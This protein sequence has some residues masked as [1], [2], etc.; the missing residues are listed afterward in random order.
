MIIEK[1]KWYTAKQLVV[2]A[3]YVTEKYGV[4]F[5][6]SKLQDVGTNGRCGGAYGCNVLAKIN[7]FI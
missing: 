1:G 2:I 4:K 6:G 7:P 5:Y 3:K